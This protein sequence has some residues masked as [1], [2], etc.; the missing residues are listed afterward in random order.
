LREAQV[1][2]AMGQPTHAR[3]PEKHGMEHELCAVT[4]QSVMND[5][6]REVD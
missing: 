1:A 2:D 3:H 6:Q 5:R 4:D